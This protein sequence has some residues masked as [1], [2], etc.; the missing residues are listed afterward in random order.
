[1]QEA[2]FKQQACVEDVDFRHP[3]GLDRSVFFSLADCQWINAHHNLIITG[4]TGVGKTFIACALGNKACRMRYT[5]RYWRTTRLLQTIATAR[6]DGSYASLIRKLQ[7]TDLLLLDDWGLTPFQVE[8][9][10]DLFEIVEDRNQIRSTLITSQKPVSQWH[11]LLADPTLADA[12]AGAQCLQ[13]GPEGRFHAQ[14]Y[15]HN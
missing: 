3:R 4:P 13:N 8:E 11:D 5:V 2:K 7:K 10:R 12:I 9:V 1:M 14:T 15:E 6:A